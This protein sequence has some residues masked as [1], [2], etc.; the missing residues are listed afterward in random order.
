MKGS[1]AGLLKGI[2]MEWSQDRGNLPDE[3]KK[4]EFASTGSVPNNRH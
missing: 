3:D 4:G 1:E 2:V